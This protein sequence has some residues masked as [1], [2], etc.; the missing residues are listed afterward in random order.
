MLAESS[1]SH[2]RVSR[3]L[4]RGAARN[5]A[6]QLVIARR[7]QDCLDVVGPHV[8]GR[9]HHCWMVIQ[10]FQLWVGLRILERG[11]WQIRGWHA[12]CFAEIRW[13]E[14]TEC[15]VQHSFLRCVLVIEGRPSV[16]SWSNARLGNILTETGLPLDRSYHTVCDIGIWLFV[17]HDALNQATAHRFILPCLL[18]P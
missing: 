8:R 12:S 13:L 9:R 16:V 1:G 14:A 4:V 15:A 2:F 5:H 3:T 7:I 17:L 11:I 10:W 6:L 18:L